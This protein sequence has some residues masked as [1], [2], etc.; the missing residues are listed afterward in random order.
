M[1]DESKAWA[2]SR[3]TWGRGK[4]LI[5]NID[6][7]REAVPYPRPATLCVWGKGISS[8]VW[9][10]GKETGQRKRP[11]NCNN[12]FKDLEFKKN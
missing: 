6:F 7:W 12:N 8:R 3:M 2:G 1:R 11:T 10:K 5:S 9:Q 4:F